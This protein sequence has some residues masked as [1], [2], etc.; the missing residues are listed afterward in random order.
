MRTIILAFSI[1][2]V[3]FDCT[4]QCSTKLLTSQGDSKAYGAAL[5]NLYSYVGSNDNGDYSQGVY[6]VN[7]H[8]AVFV[9]VQ[10]GSTFTKWQLVITVKATYFY[11]LVP[12]QV[13]LTFENGRNLQLTATDF[14]QNQGH[15]ICYFD[16]PNNQL[17]YFDS[18]ITK[19]TVLDTRE[20]RQI[21][22][23]PSYKNVLVEQKKCL[24]KELN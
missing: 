9:T 7:G 12:R 4:A 23:A 21:S 24:L 2:L 15:Q 1:F 10:G 6:M 8:L 14:N 13:T 22:K 17:S 20:K 11:P 16:I 3:C 19:L 5:E 18:G